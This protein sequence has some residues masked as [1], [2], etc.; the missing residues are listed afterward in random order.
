M[1]ISTSRKFLAAVLVIASCQ[2]ATAETVTV[3]EPGTLSTLI[4]AAAKTTTTSLK[5]NGPL[6]GADILFLRQMM[7]AGLTS[8]ETNEGVLAELDLSDATIVA[9]EDL[10]YKTSKVN[11]TT[12][13]NV[14]GDWMFNNCRTLTSIKLPKTVTRIGQNAFLRLESLVTVELPEDLVTID[15]SAFS[16][17]SAIAELAFPAKLDTIQTYAFQTASS[18]K[19][20]SFADGATL[21][22]V[23]ESAF[24]YCTALETAELP[25]TV[26]VIAA[27]AFSGDAALT[28]FTFP[29]SLKE[30]GNN[31]FSGCT[32]LS[33]ISEIP[34]GVTSLGYGIFQ[35]VPL[36][37]ISVSKDNTSYVVQDNVLFNAG[38]TILMYVPMN[39]G[40]T[41]Y[42]VPSTVTEILNFAFYKVA[43]L[44]ELNLNEGLT[45]IWNTAFAQTSLETLVIPS[46]VTTISSYMLEGCTALTGV[47]I[48]GTISG[49]P[50]NAFREAANMERIA[51][52]QAT[53]PTFVK[54]S[55]YGNPATIYVYVPSESI[56]A[57][58]TAM[59]V[60]NRSSYV[61]CDINTS[62]IQLP[63]ANSQTPN[64]TCYD[65]LGRPI[66]GTAKG[67]FIKK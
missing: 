26:E 21:R 15:K 39:C 48:L 14:I 11:Y 52:A 43:T 53:P 44:K 32:G 57:Y 56:S 19:K 1:Q 40:K 63:T 7:T 3:T 47:T 20:I 67:L 61:F 13:D 12:A 8:S 18:L 55:F 23:G 62:D 34:A 60:A 30:M 65:L 2:Y 64:A 22:Y 36:S 66:K 4:D 45:T 6:N 35:G 9:S 42:T 25:A 51:F 29:T 50:A 10:Y 27:S 58:E 37:T 54:N 31:V 28:S 5:V 41:T 46:T 59:A 33:E 49:V 17:S 24:S 16:Y 38:K